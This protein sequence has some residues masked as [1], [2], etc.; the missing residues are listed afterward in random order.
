MALHNWRAGILAGVAALALAACGGE[1]AGQPAVSSGTPTSPTS[2]TQTPPNIAPNISGAPSTDATSGTSYIFQPTATDADGDTLTF[3]AAGLPSWASINPTDGTVFGTPTDADVGDTADITISVSDGETITALAAYRIKIHGKENSTPTT[4]VM[5]PGTNTAPSI[6]G[7][8]GTAVQATAAYSF[9]PS[10]NDP[11]GQMLRFSVANKPTWASFSTTTGRL[12]GTP[13][14]SDVKTFSNIVI[15][16]SD[17]SLSAAL[18]AFAITVTAAPN[19]APTIT[20]SAT[21][22]VAAGS[23]YSFTP[24]GVDPDGQTLTYSIAN[25]PSWA[26]FSSTTGRLFGTPSSSNVGTFSNI[27]ITVSDGALSAALPAFAITVTSS[28]RAPTIS[29]TPA[30]SVAGGSAYSFTPSA[31]DPDGNTLAFS[32][33][34]KPAWA[35]F[36][37]ATGTLTGTPTTAQAGTYANILIT[38]SDGSL[39]QLL[40]AFAIT[41]TQ[42]SA[43]G[44]ATLSWNPP[45]QNTDGTSLTDLAGYRVYHGTNPASLTDV[46]Q[47]AGASSSGYTYT[48]LTSG[49]HYFAVSAYTVGGIESAMSTVGSKTIP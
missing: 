19:R 39:S 26:S 45:T 9:T 8:P 40:P 32:I 38:V 10:A 1:D 7:A 44:S 20:G 43:T 14:T 46:V 6:S 49:T 11:D 13:T 37:T 47:V 34:G 21:N 36:S 4:P 28:N 17:G 5:P 18:P 23:A 30:T 35:T 2:P 16:V 12:S 15:A 24:T 33:S 31:S 41:V 3:S 29:G 25:K 27:T 48:Q 22:S 42:P